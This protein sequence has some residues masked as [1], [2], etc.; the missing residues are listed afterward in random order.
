MRT[1]NHTDTGA[2]AVFV[3][4]LPQGALTRHLY[5][6]LLEKNIPLRFYHPTANGVIQA[7][8]F[9]IRTIAI[10]AEPDLPTEGLAHMLKTAKKLGINFCAIGNRT[11]WESIIPPTLPELYNLKVLAP[12]SGWEL[13]LLPQQA[14][15]S[16]TA[17]TDI[18]K[19]E[20]PA[21]EQQQT[22]QNKQKSE[23]DKTQPLTPESA[24]PPPAP[25][26][27]KEDID[28]FETN[29]P[30][31]EHETDYYLITQLQAKIRRL[32]VLVVLLLLLIL[33]ESTYIATDKL[34]YSDTPAIALPPQRADDLSKELKTPIRADSSENTENETVP[35]GNVPPQENTQPD[36]QTPNPSTTDADNI[37]YPESRCEEKN[38]SSTEQ[39]Q[40]ICMV[41]G[42][43]SEAEKNGKIYRAMHACGCPDCQKWILHCDR[44]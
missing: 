27:E 10:A 22:P 37:R 32:Q 20:K 28:L 33:G 18:Q 38:S 13:P 23:E 44:N 19:N 29:P 2:S 30:S 24:T 39:S 11:D 40:T 1:S 5:K 31:N 8:Q 21:S 9:H 41:R 3:F 36:E 16:C 4:G 12:D 34:F 7:K 15:H 35:K 14:S 43:K 26:E 42:N 17:E 25:E 6:M